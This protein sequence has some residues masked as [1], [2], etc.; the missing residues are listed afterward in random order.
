MGF[1]FV[2]GEGD[3]DG[4]VADAFKA[5]HEIREG[6]AG[7]ACALA[8]AE[9]LDMA[10]LKADF[11]LVGAILEGADLFE[12]RHIA[13]CK[14][15]EGVL[16]ERIDDIQHALHVLLTFCAQVHILVGEILQDIRD[17]LCMIAD[18]LNVG[19][20]MEVSGNEIGITERNGILIDARK[21]GIDLLGEPVDIMLGVVDLRETICV[22]VQE[23]LNG[24]V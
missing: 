11:Q 16:H 1:R 20:H 4:M 12:V 14:H 22:V 21:V 23:A 5:G 7:F 10:I 2:E 17:I 3:V 8:F 18:T 24:V 19:V 15:I 9:A 6:D 13:G